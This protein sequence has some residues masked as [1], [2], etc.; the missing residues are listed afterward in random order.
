MKNNGIFYIAGI[1]VIALYI[2]T[3]VLG[4]DPLQ[5][6]IASKIL[7]FHVLANS[8]TTCDQAVKEDVRDAVGTYLQ[9]LLEDA[10][11]LEETKQIIARNLGAIVETA[12]ATLEAQGYDYYVTARIARIDFPKKTYG[13]YTFPKGEYEALQIVIGEG[14]GQNWWCVL[15]PNMCFK[16]SVF[17]VVEEEAEASLK[18]VLNPWEYADVFDSGK[19]EFRFK[20]LEYFRERG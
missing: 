13:S 3:V 9:P 1:A 15:Y 14:E 5:P 18:E 6:S 16:G 20:F 12:K 11:S 19:V 4:N 2:W 10:E 8:D 17:E 7:R